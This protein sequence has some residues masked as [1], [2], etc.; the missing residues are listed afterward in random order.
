MKC[1]CLTGAT[2]IPSWNENHIVLT[3]L[4]LYPCKPSSSLY[5]SYLLNMTGVVSFEIS[6]YKAP[7]RDKEKQRFEKMKCSSQS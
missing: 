2:Y 1:S 6:G 4:F 7:W 3:A 5:S